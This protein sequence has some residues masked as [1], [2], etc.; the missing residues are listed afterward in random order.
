[1]LKEILILMSQNN[2]T[3]KEI[4]HE[5]NI[6]Y[7]DLINRL[8]MMEHMGYIKAINEEECDR[9]FTCACCPLAGNKCSDTKAFQENQK[10]FKITAK[11][12]KIID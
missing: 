4:S 12:R 10:A 5:L 3:F 1:M 2:M 7:D 9:N 11:G 6:S 8:E